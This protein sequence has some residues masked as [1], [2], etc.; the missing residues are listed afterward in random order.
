MQ[1]QHL[2]TQNT[3]GVFGPQVPISMHIDVEVFMQSGHVAYRPPFLADAHDP[4][5][6]RISELFAFGNEPGRAVGL[7]L[8]PQ[9]YTGAA[10]AHRESDFDARPAIVGRSD[11]GV[12]TGIDD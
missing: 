9:D 12:E 5:K 6:P 10:A 3:D 11:G 4:V 2:N 1:F 8:R 7:R